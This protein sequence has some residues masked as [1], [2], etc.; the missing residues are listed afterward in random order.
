MKP[1]PPLILILSGKSKIK[2]LRDF[3][4]KTILKEEIGCSG[5]REIGPR[6]KNR[7]YDEIP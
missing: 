3:F 1:G 2:A 6:K 4:V 5:S 7:T